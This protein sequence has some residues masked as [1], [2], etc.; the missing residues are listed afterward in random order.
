MKHI[1]HDK[2]KLSY[3]NETDQRIKNKVFLFKAKPRTHGRYTGGK[4]E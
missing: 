2:R 3:S 4:R 1:K